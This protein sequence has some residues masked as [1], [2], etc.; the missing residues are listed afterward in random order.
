MYKERRRIAGWE[1]NALPW[2]RP[3]VQLTLAP[4]D[5]WSVGDGCPPAAPSQHLG[6]YITTLER[7]F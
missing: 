5:G 4:A 3:F 1:N 7:E 2:P 6:H